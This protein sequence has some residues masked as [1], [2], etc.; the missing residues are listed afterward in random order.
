MADD[1]QVDDPIEMECDC[2]WPLM[3]CLPLPYIALNMRKANTTQ[4]RLQRMSYDGNAEQM[5]GEF[6]LRM[7]HLFSRRAIHYQTRF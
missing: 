7:A 4:A 5:S 2:L 1:T 3:L 6:N